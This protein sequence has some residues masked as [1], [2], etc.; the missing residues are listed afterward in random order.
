M[1]T[2][3]KAQVGGGRGMVPT[4]AMKKGIPGTAGGSQS[5]GR[6]TTGISSAG[7][8]SNPKKISNDSSSIT[9]SLEPKVET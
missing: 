6:P 4:T 1:P 8:S 2:A 9:V 5:S 3:M 7:Y